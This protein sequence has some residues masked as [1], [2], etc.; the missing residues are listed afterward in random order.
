MC[1]PGTSRMLCDLALPVGSPSSWG[2]EAHQG[3]ASILRGLVAGVFVVPRTV[4]FPLSPSPGFS[5]LRG[6]LGG[7]GPRKA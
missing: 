5:C 7:P 1:W 4:F 2:L 6:R 3:C